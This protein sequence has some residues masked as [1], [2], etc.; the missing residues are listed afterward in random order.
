MTGSTQLD[1]TSGGQRVT[2]NETALPSTASYDTAVD[3]L[4]ISCYGNRHSR[5]SGKY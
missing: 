4:H 5:E 3:F 1:Q 2:L